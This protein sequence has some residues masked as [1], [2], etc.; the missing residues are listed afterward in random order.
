MG[1]MHWIVA[2]LALGSLVLGSMALGSLAVGGLL[3]H[4]LVLVPL[5]PRRNSR[6]PLILGVCCSRS[7]YRATINEVACKV[8][9]FILRQSP[10]PGP[11]ETMPASSAPN[12]RPV[13]TADCCEPIAVLFLRLNPILFVFHS[14]AIVVTVGLLS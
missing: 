3:A 10:C 14:V 9:G 4:P 11:V 8:E 2:T 5:A 6:C 1:R 13:H 7:H 12:F